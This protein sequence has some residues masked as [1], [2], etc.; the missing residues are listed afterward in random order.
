MDSIA[1]LEVRAKFD[2]F[3]RLR[4]VMRGLAADVY[5]DIQ[6]MGIPVRPPAQTGAPPHSAPRKNGG[7]R[8]TRSS[9]VPAEE[10]PL[11][12]GRL[13]V[14]EQ[15]ADEPDPVDDAD[16]ELLR[17]DDL[18][19]AATPVPHTRRPLRLAA[20]AN[21][22]EPLVG[23]PAP[24]TAA[25]SC[26]APAGQVQT[27]LGPSEYRVLGRY[28]LLE[29]MDIHSF[30]R[31]RRELKEWSSAFSEEVGRTPSLSDAK[32]RGGLT[33]YRKFVRYLDMRARMRGLAR[34]MHVLV[35]EV[36]DIALIEKVTETGKSLLECLKNSK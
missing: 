33:L 15:V 19:A 22:S 35:D 16:T 4:K 11:N 9:Q 5:G 14:E 32:Q 23:A 30:F 10:A 13:I 25:A 7:Q 1:P 26:E 24:V 8:A 18:A 12:D 21:V 6:I 17:E 29:T 34:E 28:R 27:V 31:L 3:C 2:H 20:H 36:E